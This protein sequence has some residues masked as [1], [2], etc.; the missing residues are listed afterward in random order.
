MTVARKQVRDT[1]Q[2]GSIHAHDSTVEITSVAQ[3][4]WDQITA[5]DAN[6]ISS[7]LVVPDHTN[8]HITVNFTG[9]CQVH[10]HWSGHGPNVAHD[11]IFQLAK[12]NRAAQYPS[13]TAHL[14]TPST[15]KET[16]TS[17]SDIV[18]VTAGDTLEL[19]TQRRSAGSNII[20]TTVHAVISIHK[21]GP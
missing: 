5:F 13:V 14:T 6:G 15:Q 3:N 9:D 20:L 8:D 11:W 19:W 17:A 2:Y 12:N 16:A 4:D 18:S 1:P 10:V 21:V 7:S